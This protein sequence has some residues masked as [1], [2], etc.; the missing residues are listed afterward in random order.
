VNDGDEVVACCE[1]GSPQELPNL[2]HRK[3]YEEER[4]LLPDHRITVR[5]KG[6]GDC[7]MGR[8]VP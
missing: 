5:S 1:C 4:D 8:R 3:Q 2:H 6:A 7:V